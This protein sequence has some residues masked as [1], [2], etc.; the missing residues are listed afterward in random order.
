MPSIAPR[1]FVAA[2]LASCASAHATCYPPTSPE[3]LALDRDVDDRPQRAIAE[4][5]RRL[6]LP[7]TARN[8]LLT[9]EL[10]AIVAEASAQ[11]SRPDEVARH[12]ADSRAA[13]ERVPAGAARENA[14][15]R[16]QHIDATQ[17]AMTGDADATARMVEAALTRVPADSPAR[18]CLLAARSLTYLQTRA[19]EKAA[20]DA[21]EAYE[22]A[23]AADDA[24]ARIN[25]AYHLA[26]IYRRA[27]LLDQAE[28]MASEVAAYGER[29]QLFQLSMI[30][31][32]LQAQVYTAAKKHDAALA[33][34][35]R[36]RELAVE[37]GDPVNVAAATVGVCF[38]LNDSGRFDDADALC[39]G[40]AQ[41]LAKAQRADLLGELRAQ[42]ARI[43][44]A[45]GRP[46]DAVR[47]LDAVLAK[48]ATPLGPSY[49]ARYLRYRAAAHEATGDLRG[50]LDDLRRAD[51]LEEDVSTR[52]HVAAVSVIGAMN[53]RVR[54]LAEQRA[55]QARVDTQRRDLAT[56]RTLRNVSIG[57]SAVALVLVA[58]LAWLLRQSMRQR[59]ALRRQEAMLR[60]VVQNAPDALVL[61]DGQRAVR[62]ANRSLFGAGVGHAPGEP[63]TDVVPEPL[64][65]PLRSALDSVYEKQAPATTLALRPDGADAVAYYEVH[66]TPVVEDGALVGA[67][68]RA[69]DVTATH[70][71]ER[72]VV[73]ASNRERLRLSSDLHEGLG[74][75]LAGTA[76]LAR[77]VVGDLD[78]GRAVS[79]EAIL[80]IA[81][82]LS[83]AVDSAREIAR[84]LSPIAVERGSLGDAL[85]RLAEDADDPSGLRV[86]AQWV[87]N[88]VVV[89]DEAADHLYRIAREAVIN[90]TKHGGGSRIEIALT[91][92]NDE[93]VLAVVDDGR[94]LPGALAGH[95]LGLRMIEY[96]ARL[97]GGTALIQ[98]TGGGGTRVEVRAPWSRCRRD[99]ASTAA[100]PGVVGEAAVAN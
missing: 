44:L 41:E 96:R 24:Y 88:D 14:W 69:A 77:A 58:L 9:A 49:L 66:G 43:A 86:L 27:G 52:E 76:M 84:D 93:L 6:A 18:S 56:Q 99:R 1:L 70:R 13:L 45:R 85:R 3:L 62:Y 57:F 98:S 47:L 91:R 5:L 31:S 65:A 21:I 4:G 8:P 55:L 29:L 17:R 15:V 54:G 61:L 7:E 22:I 30:T 40:G 37:S 59:Q 32:F 42:Q 10:H 89:N 38:A 20:A 81:D 83:D 51:V 64:A 19:L 63:L 60:T 11:A 82:H 79:R 35:R 75:Q 34:A 39:R 50:A 71:L 48:G 87:A 67:L 80:E 26:A 16:L 68:V 2:L 33:A 95:G 92:A 23:S 74:Q 97:L 78:R 94:G 28:R 90:A 73:D 46:A 36:A 72:E 100:A 53:E 12:V 25:A